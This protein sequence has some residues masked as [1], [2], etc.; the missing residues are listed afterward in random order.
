MKAAHNRIDLTGEKYFEWTVISYSHTKRKQPF[1]NCLCSCG[2]NKIVGSNSLRNGSRT[3]GHSKKLVTG[4]RKDLN[5]TD[6]NRTFGCVMAR[7]RCEANRRNLTFEL[8]REE[9]FNLF[10]DT[11]Y[12]CNCLPEDASYQTG[13]NQIF[14]YMG[15]DRID[16]SIG[17]IPKNVVPCCKHCNTLKRHIP[18]WMIKKLN[19]LFIERKLIDE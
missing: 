3:C 4:R 19:K 1:W 15:I 10:K 11:C 12:Y 13:N 17:Y 8:T 6:E 14:Y 16:N 5:L 7:Y 18:I 9:T 2:T